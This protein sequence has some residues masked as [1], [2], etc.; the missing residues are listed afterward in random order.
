MNIRN[1]L[2]YVGLAA[3]ALW[4]G[5]A[6]GQI[7]TDGGDTRFGPDDP[8]TFGAFADLAENVSPAVVF[9]RV[10]VSAGGA[11]LPGVGEARGEGSGFIIHEDGLVVTNHHVV[12]NA[13]VITVVTMDGEEY[14][15]EV[16]GTDPRTDIALV[17]METDHPLPIT[18]LGE[19]SDLRVGDWVVAIGN[20]LGLEHSVTVGI[21]SALGRRD[22]RPE[23][24]DLIEDFIQTDASINP[25][26]S[27]GPLLDINGNVVGVNSAVSIAANGIGFAIP[28]DM[29]KTLLPQ[30]MNGEVIRS[31]L[32]VRTG[33]VSPEMR[34]EFALGAQQGAYVVEV[35]DGA[36]A[37]RAGIQRGDVIIKFGG[38]EIGEPREL[39]WL[40][41][42][43]G[44][45]A[46]VEVELVR[47]GDRLDRAGTIR[48]GRSG[49][50]RRVTVTMGR[51]PGSGESTG[52]VGAS[53]PTAEGFGAVVANVTPDVANDLGVPDGVGVV[54]VS[55]DEGSAAARAGLQRHDVVVMIGDESVVSIEQFQDALEPLTPGE[56]VRLRVRR[57]STTVFVAFFPD[58]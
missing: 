57:G 16:V 45:G 10:T 35:V 8:L 47:A 14:P 41:S 23:G 19:S 53:G 4:P 22:I 58:D 49:A 24:R 33:A 11:S 5:A 50:T 31:Y 32:G 37:A 3:V 39:S 43:A 29:V 26:N 12:E 18:P 44:V 2:T 9:L 27:G 42:T 28:I 55:L 1:S 46:E 52:P 30:L 15:A 40:A 51:L 13:R 17:R 20:P 25:G 36:P 48:S 7:W 54:V 21:V 56:L 34:D 6:A 38:V